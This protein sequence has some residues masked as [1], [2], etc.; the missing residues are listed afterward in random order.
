MKEND[1]ALAALLAV[2]P[3]PETLVQFSEKMDNKKALESFM[4]F[5][6]TNNLIK[7]KDRKSLLNLIN[8]HR[9]STQDL[10]PPNNLNFEELLEK[11]KGILK[12][13]FSGRILT[14]RVNALIAEHRIELPR[15]S[16][17]M[18]SRLKK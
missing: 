17:S 10:T 13:N 4:D 12:L 14:N 11:K 3:T 15:V 18:L 5:A 7:K 16:N 2:F 1:K 8:Q 6:V 9:R